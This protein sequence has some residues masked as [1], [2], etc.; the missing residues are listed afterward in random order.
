[1]SSDEYPWG[2][3]LA[4]VVA[5]QDLGEDEAGEL[6]GHVMEGHAA[7]PWLGALLA[8]LAAKGESPT[9]V[10]GF[11]RAMVAA[12]TPVEVDGPLLDT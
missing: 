10:A 12:A 9:E 3:V 1:M 11:V 8:A 7:G 2:D 6:L 4:R 5:G